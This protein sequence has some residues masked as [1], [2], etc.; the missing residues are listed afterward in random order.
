MQNIMGTHTIQSYYQIVL[1]N[2]TIKS[3]YP[4]IIS[5]HIPTHHTKQ[6]VQS[7]KCQMRVPQ[8]ENLESVFKTLVICSVFQLPNPGMLGSDDC[9]F[10]YNQF[11]NS[12]TGRTTRLVRFYLISKE[13]TRQKFQVQSGSFYFT[14]GVQPT[15]A[16]SRSPFRPHA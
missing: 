8:Q 10:H 16:G 14:S 4:I 2:H 12:S 1:S 11:Q 13:V 3:Y 6:Y 5:S 15:R 7:L 9:R